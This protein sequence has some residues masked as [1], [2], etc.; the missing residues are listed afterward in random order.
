MI[1]L[2]HGEG[3]WNTV[4]H[5]AR[6]DAGIHDPALTQTGHAQAMAAAERLAGEG[7]RRL[8]AS[9][10][11]RT[12]ETASRIADRLGLDIEVEPL[13]RE[14]CAFSCDQGSPTS[15][16][17]RDWP[18]LDFGGLDEIWWGRRIESQASLEARAGLFLRR[19]AEASDLAATIVVT[20]WGFIRAVTGQAIGNAEQVRFMPNG[21]GAERP[22]QSARH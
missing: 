4:F 15:V 2:R 20:H 8:L 6:V 5:A 22:G 10:Y 11:R 7:C 16:L 12:L 21:P 1:L 9:P 19:M 13:V 14:R 3:T 18:M 17:A